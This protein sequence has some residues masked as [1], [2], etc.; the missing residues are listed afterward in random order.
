MNKIE[1]NWESRVAAIWKTANAMSPEALVAA[2]DALAAERPADDA[3]ALFE[4]AC[5]RDTAGFE[6]DAETYYRAALASE[7]LDAYRR[8]RASI[9]LGSTLR[10]L[11]QLDESEIL[12]VAELDRHMEAGNPR[13]LHDEARA[14]LAMTYIAQGRAVEAAGLALLTL[15][16]HLSRYNRSMAANAAELVKKTWH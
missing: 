11:G 12:L 15:A 5:A 3:N 13:E 2:I 8:S 9:Q 16:P 10:I 7:N 6:A 4:R 14:I 1:N